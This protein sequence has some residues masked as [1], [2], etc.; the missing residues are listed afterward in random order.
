MSMMSRSRKGETIAAREDATMIAV[1]A[2]SDQR[3]GRN[4]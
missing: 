3:Y 1:T 2:T 4:S